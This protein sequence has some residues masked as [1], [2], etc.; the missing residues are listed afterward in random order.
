MVLVLSQPVRGCSRL[1]DEWRLQ[2]VIS[3]TLCYIY[4]SVVVR[5]ACALHSL[6]H[7]L[8]VPNLLISLANFFFF[9]LTQSTSKATFPCHGLCNPS[10]TLVTDLQFH[11]FSPPSEEDGFATHYQT[12]VHLHLHIS[13]FSI[14]FLIKSISRHFFLAS[15]ITS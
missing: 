5:L 3:I 15:Q 7:L 8:F 10:H 11:P 2:K 14:Y 1:N 4:G 13:E 6:L 12:P 9:Y